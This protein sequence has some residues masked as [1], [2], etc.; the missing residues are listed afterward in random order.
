[1]GHDNKT[2]NMAMYFYI[3]REDGVDVP[4]PTDSSLRVVD[5]LEMCVYSHCFLS[6]HVRI[7]PWEM[8]RHVKMLKRALKKDGLEN[9]VKKGSVF[10]AVYDGLERRRRRR[11]EIWIQKKM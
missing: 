11:N 4:K 2:V 7:R 9:T 6:C 3:F 1:M 5:D 10:W 8:M